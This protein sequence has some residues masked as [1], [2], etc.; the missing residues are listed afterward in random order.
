MQLET[1]YK[2]LGVSN[3]S[4]L[5]DIK[6]SFRKKAKVFHPDV[7]KS[8][9]AETIFKELNAAYNLV[10]KIADKK[11]SAPQKPRKTYDTKNA[12]NLYS[13]NKPKY[14]GETQVFQFHLEKEK[15][16]TGC[17]VKVWTLSNADRPLGVL[18]ILPNS[19]Y[20]VEFAAIV[21]GTKILIKLDKFVDEQP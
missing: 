2:I 12:I 18:T 9:N 17:T 8:P 21:R 1:A 14:D 3:Q 7:N 20:H 5:Q 13:L 10:I 16:D 19:P 11:P 6:N 15:F 4:S